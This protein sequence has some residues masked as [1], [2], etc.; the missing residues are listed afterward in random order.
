LRKTLGAALKG[1]LE[2]FLLRVDAQVIE[3]VA[4]LSELY[5]ASFVLALHH[6]S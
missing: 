3:E 1:A 2:R 5:F 6:S 4:S